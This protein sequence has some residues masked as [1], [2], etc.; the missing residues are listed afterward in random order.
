[1]IFEAVT[2]GAR[3]GVLPAPARRVD[4]DPV[5]AVGQLIH[6]GHAT[7]YETWTRNGR[8]LPPAKRLHETAR[9]A[10]LVLTRLFNARS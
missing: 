10:E 7:D 3:T 2:A 9:C 1:M 6:A 4:A 5:R 8:Q